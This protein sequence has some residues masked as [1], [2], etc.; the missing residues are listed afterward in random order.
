[1]LALIVAVACTAG[2]VIMGYPSWCFFFL[3]TGVTLFLGGL[4]VLLGLR[5]KVNRR[6]PRL[7]L[8]L[9]A[10]TGI[11]ALLYMLT[12]G[13]FNG[14]GL[15]NLRMRGLVALTGGQ[16]RLQSWAVEVLAQPR[17]AEDG[18]SSIEETFTQWDVPRSSWSG[19][20]RRLGP[21]RVFIQRVFQDGQEGVLLAYGSGFLHWYI[22]IGPP[23]S[24][25]DPKLDEHPTDSDWFRWSDG[26]YCW[27]A[28]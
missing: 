1:M 16:G 3:V 18:R 15:L 6:P 8:N 26:V 21:K 20:V 14:T 28:D 19:Q 12:I 10:L 7:W 2:A 11:I 5:H 24:V 13:P 27:F 17:D 25:P 9:A 23:G 22:V 4:A